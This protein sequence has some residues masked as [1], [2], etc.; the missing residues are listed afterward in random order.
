M[1]TKTFCK[2]NTYSMNIFMQILK[3]YHQSYT[4]LLEHMKWNQRIKNIN[5]KGTK[6]LEK[7]GDLRGRD[8]GIEL[9]GDFKGPTTLSS[10]FS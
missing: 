9:G 6:Q 8:R 1:L 3:T 10:L 7:S 4:Y 5:G 2:N